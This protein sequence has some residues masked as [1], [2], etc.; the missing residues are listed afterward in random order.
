MSNIV[1]DKAPLLPVA[2][3]LIAGMATGF[4][5]KVSTILL[6]FFVGMVVLAFLLR[7]HAACQTVAIMGSIA[8]LGMVLAGRQLENTHRYRYDKSVGQYRAIVISELTERPKSMGC[9]VL[10]TND[11]RKVRCYLQKNERSRQLRPGDGL[12]LQTS[13]RPFGQLRQGKFDYSRYMEQHGYAGQC[14]ARDGQWTAQSATLTELP[15]MEQCKVRFLRLRHR[16]LMK[17]RDMGAEDDSY[18]VL[19]AMT[20]GDKSALSRELRDTYSI[21][22]ASH[23]LALSGLHLGILY[24]L[25]SRLTMR[26]RFRVCSQALLVA[27]IWAFVMLT[28]MPVSMVRSA[29]MISIF[30]VFATG[31]RPNMSVNLLCLAA[32]LILLQ[33][34]YAL[35]D[36]GFQLS[37]TTVLSIL[38]L[39]PLFDKNITKE[40]P[41]NGLTDKMIRAVKDCLAISVA[42]QIGVAPLIAFYFGRFSTYFLLTNLIVVPAAYLI[43]YGTLLMLF[44]PALSPMV[45]GIVG[46]LNKTLTLIAHLPF[47]CIEGL[48]PNALQIVLCYLLVAIIYTATRK[49]KIMITS[50]A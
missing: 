17:Y 38:V 43:L 46:M 20:L 27:A 3:S 44:I 49:L 30:A 50:N 35:Y 40:K 41:R 1:A 21:T 16:L 34:P 15:L 9:D 45:I 5:L 11:G 19:A 7:R 25:F 31:Y 12:L 22:G 18:A 10:L 24:L 28:G 47:A 37:F 26:R 23:V 14:Y 8:L 2:V 39:M 33:N 36:V 13:I 48:H 29:I 42:A 6:P 32:I 4:A